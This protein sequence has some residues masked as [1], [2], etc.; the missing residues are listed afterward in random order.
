VKPRKL[1]RPAATPI[2]IEHMYLRFMSG[3]GVPQISAEMSFC[4]QSVTYHLRNVREPTQCRNRPT[5]VLR[6]KY[7]GRMPHV[8]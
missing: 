4:Q 1:R 2:E 6:N 5:S 3:Q 7:G 8:I